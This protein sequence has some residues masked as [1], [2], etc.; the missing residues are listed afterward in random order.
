MAK[1]KNAIKARPTK[2]SKIPVRTDIASIEAETIKRVGKTLSTLEIFLSKWDAS[3]TKPDGMFPQ[4]VKIKKFYHALTSWQKEV[5]G[6]KNA[7]DETR[8]KRLQDF[9]FIC[10]NYS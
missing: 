1:K 10:K 4:V 9:V 7:N 3:E 8:T 6:S 2:I 5:A